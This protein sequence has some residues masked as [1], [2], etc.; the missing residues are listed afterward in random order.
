MPPKWRN[1]LSGCHSPSGQPHLSP[2]L[3]LYSTFH[4]WWACA[5]SSKEVAL[6]S[7]GHPFINYLPKRGSRC[8]SWCRIRVEVF[9]VWQ[10]TLGVQ[11]CYAG[12]AKCIWGFQNKGLSD[13]PLFSHKKQ[14]NRGLLVAILL[15]LENCAS[16]TFL[17]K[18]YPKGHNS[19]QSL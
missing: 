4:S 7:S 10:T 16:H 9:T 1:L 14:L 5:T 17:P 8:R 11:P 19:S 6:P 18:Y 12:T 3:C 15:H 2:R 13:L